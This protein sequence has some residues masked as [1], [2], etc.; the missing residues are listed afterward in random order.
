MNDELNDPKYLAILILI[1]GKS[2]R[3]GVDKGSIEF[4]GKPLILY[5][6]ETLEQFDNDV[7]LVAHSAN[8]IEEYFK[9]FKIPREKFIIDDT[10]LLVYDKIRTPLIGIYSGLKHLNELNFKKAFV[11]S[12]DA[13]LIKPSVIEFL[14]AQSKGYDAVIP[15]WKNGYLE[16]LFTIY[17]VSHAL[18]RAKSL[19]DKEIYT[20]NELIDENWKIKYISVEDSIQPLDKNLVSLININGPIDIEKL[21]KFY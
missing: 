12:C 3:F 14:I 18:I 10:E 1:G 19:I 2:R 13:P 20:L 11:L 6:T 4:L 5:Q 9:K 15:R 7:F 17:P 21:K 8:Q 16:T